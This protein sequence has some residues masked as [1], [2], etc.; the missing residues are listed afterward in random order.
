M[1][2]VKTVIIIFRAAPDAAAAAENKIIM[3]WIL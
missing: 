1:K 3:I 2:V